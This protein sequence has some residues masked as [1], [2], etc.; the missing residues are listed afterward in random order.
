MG[1]PTELPRPSRRTARVIV[2]IALASCVWLGTSALGAA[3]SRRGPKTASRTVHVIE[4]AVTDTTV[5]SGGA[6]DKTGNLLTFHNKVY[7]T[8]DAK[9]VGTD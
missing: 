1:A 3:K 5:N 7:D 4:H 8:Q 6:G 9:Q 2:L